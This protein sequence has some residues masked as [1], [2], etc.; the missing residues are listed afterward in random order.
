MNARWEGDQNM[1]LF[2]THLDLAGGGDEDED[3]DDADAERLENPI[4]L[5]VF[6]FFCDL[7]EALRRRNKK[8]C[9][10]VCE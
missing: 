7:V 8:F 9:R 5:G 1:K 2:K 10:D 3:D 6:F 4:P